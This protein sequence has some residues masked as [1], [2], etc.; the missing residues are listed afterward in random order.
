M[1][2]GFL[3]FGYFFFCD[4]TLGVPNTEMRF[5]M[6]PDVFGW[7]LLFVGLLFASCYS[8]K[9]VVAKY[10]AAVMI[11][12]ALF[13][14]LHGLCV[15][16]VLFA[17]GFYTSVYPYLE[18]VIKFLFHYYLIFGLREIAEE[19]GDQKTLCVRLKSN[20]IL[21]L[22]CFFWIIGARIVLA[23]APEMQGYCMLVSAFSTMVYLL[24][25]AFTIFKM[26][27]EITAE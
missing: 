17:D 25:N 21:T 13:S 23:F 16:R 6:L 11:L 7:V 22:F 5:D 2:F 27:R 8:K 15:W 20:F 9:L 3:L 18:V 1:G 14:L 24:L 19:C 26:F 12:P 10:I 4:F